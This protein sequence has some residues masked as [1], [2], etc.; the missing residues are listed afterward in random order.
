MA[1]KS[2]ILIVDDDPEVLKSLQIW[3]KNEGFK[4]FTAGSREQAREIVKHHDITVCLADLRL[5]NDDGLRLGAELRTLDERLK[6]I[7]ITGYPT[8]ES[9]IDA[10]KNGV[11]D[12]ISKSTDN[13]TIL[14]KVRAAVAARDS[15]CARTMPDNESRAGI[16]LVGHHLL[17]REGLEN[18][19]KE[20]ADYR[21]LQT[22]HAFDFVKKSDFNLD[23]VVL[24]VCESCN[25]AFLADPDKMFPF[26]KH[27]FPNA[28]P[29]IINCAYTDERK[30]ELLRHGVK[31]F[32]PANIN[33]LQLK[34]ALDCILAGQ[35]WISRELSHKLLSDLLDDTSPE[36][37]YQR[38][39]NT[40]ELTNREIEILKALASG[41]SNRT[42]SEKL[43]LSEKTVKTHTHHIFRKMAVKTRTQAVLKAMEFHII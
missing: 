31:G 11:F 28:K 43:F 13:E 36:I 42:I 2:R 41:L 9:A 29:I 21:L 30:K 10:M 19:F 4:V 27:V 23:A 16:V 38:P 18:F 37:A 14:N 20:C 5:R 1:E 15:E 39:A 32:L 8:Y 12:Y 40:F 3:L 33:K 25:E 22:F 24:L 34:K 17:V 35:I 7:V 26:L 6:I